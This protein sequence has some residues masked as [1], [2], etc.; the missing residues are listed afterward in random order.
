MDGYWVVD[1]DSEL[2]ACTDFE[3]ARLVAALMNG[4]VA[5]LAAV[6]SAAADACLESVLE[7]FRPLRR[8]GRPMVACPIP[9][10]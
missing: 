10:L 7:T 2:V 1:G 5:A 3:A 4:D 8:D 6:A 9:L